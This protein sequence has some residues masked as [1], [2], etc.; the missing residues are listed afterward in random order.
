MQVEK[1]G[2]SESF[3]QIIGSRDERYVA[4]VDFQM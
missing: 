2:V 3:N 1:K 4:K